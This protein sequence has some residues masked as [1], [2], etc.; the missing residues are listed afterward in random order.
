M[1]SLFCVQQ[2]VASIDGNVPFWPRPMLSSNCF[3]YSVFVVT[4]N[5]LSLS[6]SYEDVNMSE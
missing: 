4:E 2:W 3:F 5:K 6:L 1:V